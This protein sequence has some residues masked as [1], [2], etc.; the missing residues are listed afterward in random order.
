VG[1]QVSCSPVVRWRCEHW[2][3]AEPPLVAHRLWAGTRVE[4]R[5]G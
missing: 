1:M 4:V 2:N 3:P 5:C